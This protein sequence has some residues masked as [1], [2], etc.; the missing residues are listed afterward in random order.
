M[1]S[2]KAHEIAMQ[3]ATQSSNTRAD[4]MVVIMGLSSL[5]ATS[6]ETNVVHHLKSGDETGN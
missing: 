1:K 6:I 4:Y 3:S 2:T 5:S